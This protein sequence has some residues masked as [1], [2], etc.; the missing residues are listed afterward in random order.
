METQL[1]L[2]QTWWNTVRALKNGVGKV[3]LIA[4]IRDQPET[5]KESLRKRVSD[6]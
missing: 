2:H 4:T 5:I 3:R 6:V 1:H